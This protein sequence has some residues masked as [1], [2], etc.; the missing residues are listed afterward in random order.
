MAR[1]VR[2][3]VLALREKEFV[4]AARAQGA[5]PIRIMFTELLPNLAS[6]IVVFF[7]LLV[8][9]AILLEAAL[10]F[11]GRRRPAARDVVGHADRLRGG[12]DRDRAAPHDR[13][14]A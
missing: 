10:S 11:L 7:T 8:A 4:E 6:T 14:R 9:N 13:A 12:A 5:G 3:Q 2:G 1:P